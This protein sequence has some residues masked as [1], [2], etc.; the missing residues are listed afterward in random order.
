M[1][2]LLLTNSLMPQLAAFQKS[3]LAST[4]GLNGLLEVSKKAREYSNKLNQVT[5][6][7]RE[8]LDAFKGGVKATP[9][10]VLQRARGARRSLSKWLTERLERFTGKAL[11]SL[12]LQVK[13]GFRL[14]Q[15]LE[16][17]IKIFPTS[18]SVNP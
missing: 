15:K 4:E 11:K 12:L 9:Y 16:S 10:Y 8:R 18:S 7:F 17:L 1:S 6:T 13:T 5:Q 3:L 14:S 2:P